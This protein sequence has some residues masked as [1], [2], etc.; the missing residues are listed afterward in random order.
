MVNRIHAFIRKEPKLKIISMIAVMI[1][2]FIV[3][4]TLL[5]YRE[6]YIFTIHDYLDSWPSLFEV[7]RRS[8]LFYSPDSNM[9]IM[10]GFS[11]CYLYFDFGIYRLLN[12]LFGFVWG[13]II[14]KTIGILAGYYFSSILFRTLINDY[15]L[16]NLQYYK[17][18]SA[19][20]NTGWIVVLL[21]GCYSLSSVYPNWTI[22]FA[23]LPL[24]FLMLYKILNEK[25][26]NHII[27]IVL[28]GSFGFFIYFPAIGIFVF[29]VFFL[30]LLVSSIIKRKINLRFL[31]YIILMLISIIVFNI[32]IFLYMFKDEP[33]NRSLI[34]SNVPDNFFDG[35]L[36]F[37]KEF[38]RVNIFGQY[39]AK[40]VLYMAIPLAVC[41]YFAL[42]IQV[43]RNK[44]YKKLKS[45]TIILGCIVLFS[46]I[47][48]LQ[49]IGLLG[50]FVTVIFPFLKGF[51]LGRIVYFNNLLWYLL[52]GV[53]FIAFNNHKIIKYLSFTAIIINFALVLTTG[54][55]N[56][57]PSNLYHDNSLRNGNV[58]YKQFFDT[59]Y[60]SALKEE[61]GYS[62]EGTISIGYH[63]AIAMYNGFN[64]L[65]GYLCINPLDYHYR[66]R[67]II[68]PTLQEYPEVADYYDTW[69]GRLYCYIDDTLNV[70]P[71]ADYDISSKQLLINTDA[72]LNMGGKYILSRYELSNAK[73]LGLVLVE[74][75]MDKEDSIYRTW[76]Y[77]IN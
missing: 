40:P 64:T 65:D 58:T 47:Y 67:E 68:E 9:P 42:I 20:S 26:D 77:K 50:S 14:N 70:E 19:D 11:T 38:I 8:G 28:S 48:A 37:F 21:S 39:H 75:K 51:N 31:L 44:Q 63:P 34:I 46:S 10:Q 25:K 45:P 62:N 29:G 59:E 16:K 69:G 61:I 41:L 56:D 13:E 12:F 32:N 15:H 23:F 66:F 55:Y 54:T 35:A 57:T 76:V 22:S 3:L 49:E 43:A 6:N 1:G 36:D 17:S 5:F 33:L 24:Y 73:D 60:F 72:F 4:G 74:K 52:I 7:L 18:I 53:L 2:A 30:L 27:N 71:V